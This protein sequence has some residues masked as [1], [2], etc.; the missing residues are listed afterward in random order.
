MEPLDQLLPEGE[1]KDSALVLFLLGVDDLGEG[2]G[3]FLPWLP[4]WEAL[5]ELPTS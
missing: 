1:T 4:L 3:Q 2:R 5:R